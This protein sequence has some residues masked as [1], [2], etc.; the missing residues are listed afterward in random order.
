MIFA[1]GELEFRWPIGTQHAQ[2][3]RLTSEK[4]PPLFGSFEHNVQ[5]GV[6]SRKQDKKYQQTIIN[7]DS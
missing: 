1:S 7:G 5:Q 3:I 4:W 6:H 2:K